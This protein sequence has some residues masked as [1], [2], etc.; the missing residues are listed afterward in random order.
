LRLER[1]RGLRAELV[2]LEAQLGEPTVALL[3]LP[4]QLGLG[5]RHGLRRCGLGR[6][7]VRTQ[8]FDQCVALVE[9]AARARQAFLIFLDLG[10]DLVGFLPPEVDLFLGQLVRAGLRDLEFLL[11]LG[12]FGALAFGELFEVPGLLLPTQALGFDAFEPVR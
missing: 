3:E 10:V 8:R 6:R 11:E 4:A 2:Q 12:D 1:R 5:V 9:L 7:A